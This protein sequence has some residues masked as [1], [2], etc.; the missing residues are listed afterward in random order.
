[1]G[2]IGARGFEPPTSCS[3]SRHSAKLSYAP[4][5]LHTL[6]LHDSRQLH[7]LDIQRVTER[8]GEPERIAE[9]KDYRLSNFDAV[10]S[11]RTP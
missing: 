11:S 4:L 8:D 9:M 2:E 5:D 6:Q 1:M 3:Q 10:T 7:P